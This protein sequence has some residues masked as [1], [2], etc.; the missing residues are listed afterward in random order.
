MDSR[1]KNSSETSR[2]RLSQSG[3]RPPA[4]T[5][6]V[7]HQYTVNPANGPLRVVLVCIRPLGSVSILS[8]R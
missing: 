1:L 7:I 3:H 5:K 6:P 2:R 4:K 8:A